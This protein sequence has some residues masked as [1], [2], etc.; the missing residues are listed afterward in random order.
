MVK[1]VR[2]SASSKKKKTR[3]NDK[4][5]MWAHDSSLLGIS[6]PDTQLWNL[7]SEHD[8][9]FGQTTS[10]DNKI[11]NIVQSVVNRAQFATS[12]STPTAFSTNFQVGSLPQAASL[13]AVFDQYRIMQIEVWLKPANIT[14]AT[15]NTSDSTNYTVIDYD[16]A[17]NL[18]TETAAVSYQNVTVSSLNEGVY[19]RFRPHQAIATYSS[20]AFG[21]FSNV[22]SQW[23]DSGSSVIQHYGF[24]FFNT[25]TSAGA[26]TYDL[27]TRYWV[28]FRNV[29]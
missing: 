5:P 3:L 12:T 15:S 21:G 4:D 8:P 14:G 27:Y 29:F 11:F 28:Q 16:D 20:G 18:S 17:A 25:G 7:T 26:V 10:R 22:P 24:K 19:R 13:L 1:R 2:K 6:F 23:N 9:R